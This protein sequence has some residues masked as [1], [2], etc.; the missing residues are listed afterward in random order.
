MAEHQ[1]PSTRPSLILRLRN[2]DDLRA[3]QEF[4]EIYQ[5]VIHA[6]ARKRCLQEADA[7]DVTQEDVFR[8]HRPRTVLRRERIRLR[9]PTVIDNDLSAARRERS[10]CGRMPQIRTMAFQGR[11]CT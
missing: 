2:A 3:W 11:R 10:N 1:T 7:E 9:L 6:I 8:C 4:V 5:P